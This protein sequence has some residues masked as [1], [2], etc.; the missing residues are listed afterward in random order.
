MGEWNGKTRGSL[1]GY[2]FFVFCIRNLG[3][4]FSYF[5][6]YFV[7]SYYVLFAKQPRNGLLKFYQQGFNYSKSE[8]RKLAF[9]NFYQF[10]KTL[11]DR[12]AIT[13]SKRKHY[14]HTF[15]NEE[16]LV[17]MNDNEKGG[18]LFSGHLG[19][20]ENAGNLIKERV[21]SKINIVML[22]AE[23]EK[24]KHFMESTTGG[25]SYQLIP[26]KDDMSH[27]ILIHKAL[28]RNEFVAIHADRIMG[29]SKYIELDFLASKA[30]FPLGPFI[31]AEK[32]KVPITFVYAVKDGR[33]HYELFAT[34]PITE[35]TKA[36]DIAKAY[37]SRLEEMVKKYPDQWFNFYDY[38]AS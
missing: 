13:T 34:D 9:Q 37:V 6:C 21:T 27:L 23:V 22:D 11:I 31:L 3:I 28:K 29:D 5:L 38:Y 14:T 25:P 12:I 24:I 4:S 35:P 36:E 20:W 2:K 15:N 1:L 30:K 18:L 8:A 19:N 17:Q 32:F 10:G 16:A 7:A 33:L 26:L